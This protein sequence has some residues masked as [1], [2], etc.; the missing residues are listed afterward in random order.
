IPGHV[1]Q[2]HLRQLCT[3]SAIIGSLAS[4]SPPPAQGGRPCP[5]RRSCCRWRDCSS[6]S[7]PRA[8]FA[9][10]S[11]VL[12][13]HCLPGELENRRRRRCLNINSPS[14]PPTPAAASRS[15]P[16]SVGDQPSWAI[17]RQVELR[18]LHA[19]LAPLLPS[20][21]IPPGF[22]QYAA[23]ASSSPCLALA[24]QSRQSGYLLPGQRLSPLGHGLPHA[25]TTPAYT[26]P[27][28]PPP[29]TPREG[30]VTKHLRVSAALVLRNLVMHLEEARRSVMLHLRL[31]ITLFGF[32]C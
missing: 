24:S 5:V 16:T 17:L 23:A 26:M 22:V 6:G 3:E 18:R 32:T 9:L 1:Y 30:P 20:S 7:L 14:I 10:Q 2:A 27:M 25:A 31:G 15:P 28:L 21:Q 12:D 29:Q 11:H 13:S 19:D 8:P 4:G